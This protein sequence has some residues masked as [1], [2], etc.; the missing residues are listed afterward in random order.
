MIWFNIKKLERL[1]TTEQFS[2]KDGYKYVLANTIYGIVYSIYISM[3]GYNTDLLINAIITLFVTLSLLPLV[4]ETNSV[5]D[6]KDFIKRFFSITWVIQMWVLILSVAI[7]VLFTFA[8]DKNDD[9]LTRR[10]ASWLSTGIINT[11]F[12]LLT[13]QSFKRIN[14]KE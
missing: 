10:V 2:E 9:S 6:N 4:F 7:T 11:I 8:F 12:Y 13:N 5:G 14:L 1:I 3:S